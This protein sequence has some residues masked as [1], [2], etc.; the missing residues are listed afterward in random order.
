[1]KSLQKVGNSCWILTSRRRIEGLAASTALDVA[2]QFTDPLA[3]VHVCE[4]LLSN[5]EVELRLAVRFHGQSNDRCGIRI[6]QLED[7]IFCRGRIE[8]HFRCDYGVGSNLHGRFQ[9]FA[10]EVA[11]LGT[12]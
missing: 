7:H 9:Q 10:F 6:F 12:V 2:A 3:R 4:G 5:P 11:C 8:G 1:M